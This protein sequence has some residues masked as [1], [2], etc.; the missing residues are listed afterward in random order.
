M[1]LPKETRSLSA[2][3]LVLSTR[4]S[5]IGKRFCARIFNLSASEEFKVTLAQKYHKSYLVG[6]LVK[7]YKHCFV[8]IYCLKEHNSATRQ[9][10]DAGSNKFFENAFTCHTKIAI[11]LKK[12]TR[13]NQFDLFSIS[14]IPRV[15]QIIY[16]ADNH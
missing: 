3:R 6:P 12:M 5:S 1:D 15:C 7:T 9:L 11:M 4:T 8:L 10:L 2:D 16:D 13:F 14:K